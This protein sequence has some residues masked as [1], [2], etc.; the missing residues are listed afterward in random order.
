MKANGLSSRNCSRTQPMPRH[1]CLCVVPLNKRRPSKISLRGDTN[2]TERDLTAHGR[3]SYNREG[4]RKRLPYAVQARCHWTPIK[5]SSRGTPC[6][7]TCPFE[8]KCGD[9]LTKN[10]L[11][12][13]HEY[14]FGITKSDETTGKWEAQYDTLKTASQWMTL[15]ESFVKYDGNNKAHFTFAAAS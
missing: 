12:G 2:P 11:F 5:E 8:G 1:L 4:R 7:S 13:C 6:L 15:M 14:S 3:G 9:Q 10:V